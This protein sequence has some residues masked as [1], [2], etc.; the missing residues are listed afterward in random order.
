M[1][2][3]WTGQNA[4]SQWVALPGRAVFRRSAAE[5]CHRMRRSEACRADCVQA[6]PSPSAH[7]PCGNR[8]ILPA[9]DPARQPRHQHRQRSPGRPD[10]S[11]RAARFSGLHIAEGITLTL[12]VFYNGLLE[13]R[14]IGQSRRGRS[15]DCAR[16]R[17]PRIK[18]WSGAEPSIGL[19]LSF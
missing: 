16:C 14:N 4:S 18:S 9:G 1:N 10:Q 19:R 13:Y 2:A 5:A 12:D 11:A 6:G 15:A 7:H 3:I 8:R 17:H